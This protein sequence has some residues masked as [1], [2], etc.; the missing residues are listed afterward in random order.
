MAEADRG[1]FA[2]NLE[3]PIGTALDI[4]DGATKRVENV[5]A[6]LPEVTRYLTTVG[7]SQS[8]WSSA[9]RPNVAQISVTL[10]EKRQR[11][12]ST[13]EVMND[14]AQQTAMIPGLKVRMSP[15]SM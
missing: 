9:K 10:Q 8:E 6:S 3:M 4:T 5:L 7:K 2:V 12:R 11:E 14:I 15:I 13:A 1:E